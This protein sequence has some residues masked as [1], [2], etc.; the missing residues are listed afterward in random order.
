MYVP[1]TTTFKPKVLP[2]TKA[3]VTDIITT[4][5]LVTEKMPTTFEETTSFQQDTSTLVET[6][7]SQRHSTAGDGTTT[8]EATRVFPEISALV[9]TIKTVLTTDS[10]ITSSIHTTTLDVTTE[11]STNTLTSTLERATE[12]NINTEVVAQS[13]T[14]TQETTS[15]KLIQSS[16]INNLSNISSGIMVEKR[17]YCY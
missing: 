1:I 16:T 14:S 7:Y 3:Q 15:S 6:N 17:M 2:T 4:T 11:P 5:Q 8:N 13:I 10:L 9:T 12:G